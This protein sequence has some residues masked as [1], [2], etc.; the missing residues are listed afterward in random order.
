VTDNKHDMDDLRF[1]YSAGPSWTLA[2]ALVA[3]APSVPSDGTLQE[4]QQQKD[5]NA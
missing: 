3:T 2:N 5:A 1:T 4:L